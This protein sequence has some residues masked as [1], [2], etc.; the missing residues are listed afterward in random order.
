MSDKNILKTITLDIEGKEIKLTPEQA[1]KL[2][3]ALAELFA[4]KEKEVSVPYPVYHPYRIW[5]GDSNPMWSGGYGT[6]A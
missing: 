3:N 5:W 4:P 6:L 2:H 1:K